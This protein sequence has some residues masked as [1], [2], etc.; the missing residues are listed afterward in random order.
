MSGDGKETSQSAWLMI[1][2]GLSLSVMGAMAVGLW[3]VRVERLP[4]YQRETERE[5]LVALGNQARGRQPSGV[6][7]EGDWI[8]VRDFAPAKTSAGRWVGVEKDSVLVVRGARAD[9]RGGDWVQA[10]QLG[11]PD[12]VPLTVHESFVE[13]YEPAVL[14]GGLEIADCRIHR[15]VKTGGT[16][17]SVSGELR[18]G[19]DQAISRCEVVCHLHNGAGEPLVELRSKPMALAGEKFGGFET[20]QV[21]DDAGVTAISLNVRYEKAGHAEESPQVLVSLRPMPGLAHE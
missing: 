11:R 19:T 8:R 17:Y 2:T 21:G 3:W 1:Q 4:A 7:H 13:R 15:Y 9:E 18:N 20:A 16:Y 5:Q 10:S 12:A 14:A 6:Y